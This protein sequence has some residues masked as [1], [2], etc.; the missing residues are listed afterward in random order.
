MLPLLK[1]LYS[2]VNNKIRSTFHSLGLYSLGVAGSILLFLLPSE[3]I[4]TTN[5]WASLSLQCPNLYTLFSQKQAQN[6]HFQSMKKNVFGLFSRE[7]G[8]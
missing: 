5:L 6:A 8:L 2:L 3:A 4:A 7:L 1:L